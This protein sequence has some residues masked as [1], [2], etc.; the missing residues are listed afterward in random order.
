MHLWAPP[1]DPW[2]GHLEHP[3][4]RP[5]GWGRLQTV[6]FQFKNDR[7]GTFW[8]GGGQL[9][10]R[11]PRGTTRDP[12]EAPSWA[13]PPRFLEQLSDPPS[14][15]R[16][17]GG[18]CKPL[19]GFSGTARNDRRDPRSTRPSERT[20]GPSAKQRSRSTSAAHA[21]RMGVT[22][23]NLNPKSVGFWV[24]TGWVF[25]ASRNASKTTLN[26]F[27]GGWLD[28]FVVWAHPKP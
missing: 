14:V 27:M 25:T 13:P 9:G 3:S 7:L 23:A 16:A 8:L 26:H 10:F 15:D 2:G 19:I 6:V 21:T 1:R 4:R 11:V 28:A 24:V 17:G 5:C 12:W 22:L 18:A 20:R